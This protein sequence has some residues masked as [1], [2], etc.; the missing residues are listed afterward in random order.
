M[1]GSQLIKNVFLDT[2]V[3]IEANFDYRSPRIRSLVSLAS[4]GIVHVFLTTITANEIKANLKEK[5]AGAVK[6]RPAKI[7][8]N[9]S[10]PAVK[11]LFKSVAA[12]AVEKELLSQLDQ[13]MKDAGVTVLRV[14]DSA[15]PD[16]LKDY[17]HRRAPFGVGKNKAEFPDA[18]ALHA[19]QRFCKSKNAWMAVITRDKAVQTACGERDCFYHYEDLAKY[20]DEVASDDKSKS[21]FVRLWVSRHQATLF[22][23]AKEQFPMMGFTLIDQDGEVV[24]VDLT[25]MKPDA[26][27]KVI[28]LAEDSA[29]VEVTATFT[30]EASVSYEEPN[31]GI[32]DREDGRVYFA[33]VMEER[34]YRDI[35]RGLGVKIEFDGLDPN[36]VGVSSVWFQ[37]S[38]DIEVESDYYADWTV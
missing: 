27:V 15:L 26:E 6:I 37:G 19:L 34:V 5:V 24:D 11:R 7:L 14:E 30:F 35:R 32:Y 31:T 21:E 22:E 13:F 1:A 10:L 25:D 3:F 23:K 9:S 17:F 4:D 16:V 36:S 29:Q 33:N 28:S 8:R 2:D 12:E 20:L 38:D 18:F